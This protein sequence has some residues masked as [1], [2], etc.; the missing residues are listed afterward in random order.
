MIYVDDYPGRV[1]GMKMSRMTGTSEQEL[2]AMAEAVGLQR[3]DQYRTSNR[4]TYY[5][6]S[7]AKRQ[8][9]IDLGAVPI[10]AVEMNE[11]FFKRKG[12]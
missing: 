6:V 8:L 10:T 1:K 3:C 12:E 9:A 2:D 5:N 7:M 11:K 4:T